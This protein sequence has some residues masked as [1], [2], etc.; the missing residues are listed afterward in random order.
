MPLINGPAGIRSWTQRIS[1]YS[2]LALG[3]LFCVL[4]LGDFSLHPTISSLWPAAGVALSGY[5]IFGR[6]FALPIV[7]GSFIAH[8]LALHGHED[9]P[10]NLEFIAYCFI[11]SLIPLFQ[12]ALNGA[13]LK[14][15]EVFKQRH[16]TNLKISLFIASSLIS[17]GIS[18]T[19]SSI[20]YSVSGHTALLNGSDSLS[21]LT[22]LISWGGQVLGVLLVCPWILIVYR[23][24]NNQG[25]HRSI[26][27]GVITPFLLT[28]G[29][30]YYLQGYFTQTTKDDS[31][32]AFQLIAQAGEN[33]IKKRIQSYLLIVYELHLEMSANPD[34]SQEDF[35]FVASSIMEGRQGIASLSWAAAFTPDYRQQF[36]N[37]VRKEIDPNFTIW[38]GEEQPGQPLVVIKLIEPESAAQALRGYNAFAVP[39]TKYNILEAKFSKTSTASNIFNLY[40][41]DQTRKGFFITKPVFQTANGGAVGELFDS[42]RIIGVATGAFYVDELLGS[43]L[44]ESIRP[45]LNMYVYENGNF[46]ES[47]FGDRNITSDSEGERYQF[48]VN[49]ANKLWTF[50][51]HADASSLLNRQA[52][53]LRYFFL[54]EIL[55]AIFIVYIVLSVFSRKRQLEDMVQAKTSALV[56][57]N[58]GLE[59]ANKDIYGINQRFSLASEAAGIGVWDWNLDTG[60]VHWEPQMYEIFGRTPDEFDNRYSTW[61]T[62]LHPEDRIKLAQEAGPHNPI[63]T[64][65]IVFRIIRGDG[66]VR[67]VHCIAEAMIDEDDVA[68]HVIGV[69]IDITDQVKASNAL[70][71]AREKAEKSAK[72]KSEFLS[73]MSH[74]IRTP[75]NGVVGLT[76]LLLSSTLN[77]EQLKYAKNLKATSGTLLNIINDILDYSKI[78]SGNFNINLS[79]FCLGDVISALQSNLASLAQK[80]KIGFSLPL[81]LY[82]EVFYRGDAQRIQQVLTNLLGNAIKFTN[83]GGVKLNILILPLDKNT[84]ELLIEVEDTGIG[85]EQNQIEKI[86]DRFTQADQSTTKLYGG[87]GLGLSISKSLVTLMDGDVGVRSELGVGSTFWIKL[88]LTQ[89]HQTRGDNEDSWE[90][91]TKTTDRNGSLQA[92]LV[93]DNRVNQ[94]VAKGLLDK[95]D[96]S[97]SIANNGAEAIDLC[98]EQAF[99]LIFM[100]C[101]M[102]VMN[103]FDATRNIRDGRAG[104]LNQQTPII[105]MTANAMP[106]DKE[107]CLACGMNDYIA[108]PIDATKLAET[109]ARWRSQA[110]ESAV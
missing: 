87:T 9:K 26:L 34:I 4:F 41:S 21:A 102:P 107:H 24:A 2:S 106:G 60:Y 45:I 25:L 31:K 58:D 84:D 66:E 67:H 30:L 86:F 20:I 64:L 94:L 28:L 85:L 6:S 92:L 98:R 11:L 15:W 47:V 5:L 104:R 35:K 91:T 88:S 82:D 23:N 100:D 39:E 79:T 72:A 81:G 49:F 27:T 101:Q 63:Q 83:R 103:G 55:A 93:E 65:D 74:E 53:D 43:T 16:L 44:D 37:Q 40:E 36:L 97:V 75:L 51:L 90:S 70:Q 10:L 12:A 13:L 19:L 32:Q 50:V 96:V 80:K 52:S 71:E 108:K 3:Y 73:N 8:L 46:N 69:N 42:E 29:S 57:A 18:V 109:T 33:Q 68:H 22:W 76:D 110:M 105:A 62:Y 7:A 56:Q 17:C 48:D 59:K 38:G 95:L 99:D 14:H 61:Q 54:G 1:A 89:S 78:E 77:S